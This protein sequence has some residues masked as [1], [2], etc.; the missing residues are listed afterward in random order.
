MILSLTVL[1]TS[2]ADNS[3]LTVPLAL[4]CKNKQ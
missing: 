3:R 4:L 1:Q 2:V